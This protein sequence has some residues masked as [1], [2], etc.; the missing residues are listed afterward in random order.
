M[1]YKDN[2]FY[3]GYSDIARLIYETHDE[4]G[5]VYFGGDGDYTIHTIPDLNEC[6]V[7]DHYAVCQVFWEARWLKIRDDW[8]TV[9]KLEVVDDSKPIIIY[10]AGEMGCLITSTKASSKQKETRNERRWGYLSFRC[11]LPSRY[12]VCTVTVLTASVLVWGM[13]P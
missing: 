1:Y 6:S 8:E 9:T 4:A 7:P 2:D 10:R 12:C 11:D 3:A 13:I 5:F